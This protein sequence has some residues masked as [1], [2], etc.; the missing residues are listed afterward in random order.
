MRIRSQRNFPRQRPARTMRTHRAPLL[1]APLAVTAPLTRPPPHLRTLRT[2]PLTANTCSNLHKANFISAIKHALRPF[3]LQETTKNCILLLTVRAP[4]I[5]VQ[6]NDETCGGDETSPP[7]RETD[8]PGVTG[9]RGNR[10]QQAVPANKEKPSSNC[11]PLQ[12]G[13]R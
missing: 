2:A 5:K 8:H 4:P 1:T 3:P 6:S 11:P 9:K 12:L 7:R 10:Q 13:C